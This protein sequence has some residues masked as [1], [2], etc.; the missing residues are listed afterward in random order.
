MER[1]K[2][3]RLLYK[4][5]MFAVL[6]LTGMFSMV[7][8]AE[9]SLWDNPYVIF[10]PDG[11]AFTTN[12][13]EADTEWYE[14]GCTVYTGNVSSLR[15]PET[16]EHLYDVI[17]TGSIRV[18]KWVVEHSHARCVH[19]KIL[20]ISNYH[21]VEFSKEICHK[22]Y[23]SGWMAYCADCDQKVVNGFLY[24]S[25]EASKSIKELDM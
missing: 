12:A 18:G 1:K 15:E 17:K 19:N 8:N 24:M 13:E 5:L 23:Y 3:K 4:S 2:R 9:A 22:D 11:N 14:N 6:F 20:N 21:G 7:C 25:K 16:G 10:S